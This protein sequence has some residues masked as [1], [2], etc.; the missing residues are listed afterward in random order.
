MGS[1]FLPYKGAFEFQDSILRGGFLNLVWVPQKQSL[2]QGLGYRCF[3]GE[4]IP[5]SRSRDGGSGIG[6]EEHSVKESAREIIIAV[7]N[8]ASVPLG[9]RKRCTERLLLHL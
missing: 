4:V 2:R 8:G 6:Q 1:L 7:F 9:P 3:N 5:R